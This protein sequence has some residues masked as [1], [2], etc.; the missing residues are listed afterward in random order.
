MT[1]GAGKLCGPVTYKFDSPDGTEGEYRTKASK[2]WTLPSVT[3]EYTLTGTAKFGYSEDTVSLTK[4]LSWEQGCQVQITEVTGKAVRADADLQRPASIEI[5]SFGTKV[6]FCGSV[7]TITASLTGD[8]GSTQSV[9]VNSDDFFSADGAVTNLTVGR[10]AQTYVWHLTVNAG[11]APTI[12]YHQGLTTGE[13]WI[14]VLSDST[15][16]QGECTDVDPSPCDFKVMVEDPVC[17]VVVDSVDIT[18]FREKSDCTENMIATITGTLHTEVSC[19][20]VTANLKLKSAQTGTFVGN[21]VP[22]LVMTDDS[23]RHV[24]TFT[25]EIEGPNTYGQ[26]SASCSG[27][28]KSNEADKSIKVSEDSLWEP[29]CYLSIPSF[30]KVS[31]Q[32]SLDG[33][34]TDL[35]YAVRLGQCGSNACRDSTAKISMEDGTGK[36]TFVHFL[37][38]EDT[39]T[40]IEDGFNYTVSVDTVGGIGAVVDWSD[41]R[42]VDDQK[43]AADGWVD[44][45]PTVCQVNV[46][47]FCLDDAKEISAGRW[48]FE[49]TIRAEANSKCGAISADL[50]LIFEDSTYLGHVTIPDNAIVDAF[51][52]DCAKTFVVEA[53]FAGSPGEV[54][55]QLDV[56]NSAHQVVQITDSGTYTIAAAT[57]S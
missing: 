50:D 12:E 24:Y 25:A 55:G 9:T 36:K 1:G 45:D 26:Y 46:V 4:K 40:A 42:A 8:D 7:T 43:A 5:T 27:Y 39:E 16:N 15:Q 29:P 13:G 19:K 21:A 52:C 22:T 31:Q 57:S 33:L 56:R 47:D 11:Q 44:T 30:T 53:D 35:S 6:G 17:N 51:N 2:T 10:D 18:G 14:Q 49:F 32:T 38:K 37:S 54:F 23:T 48:G 41:P 20:D 34:R 3:G 28:D